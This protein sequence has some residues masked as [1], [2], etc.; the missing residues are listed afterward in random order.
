[1]PSLYIWLSAAMTLRCRVIVLCLAVSSPVYA[2]TAQPANDP[3]RF[4][5]PTVFVGVEKRPQDVLNVPVSVTTV[6]RDTLQD[7]GM[8]YVND[9]A[10]VAPNVFVHEFS[11]I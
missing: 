3:V 8:R 11:E 10:R 7:A 6:Q 9:A 1:M 2:Q 4:E 5:L